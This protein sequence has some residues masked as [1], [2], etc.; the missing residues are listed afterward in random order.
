MNVPVIFA[1][2]GTRITSPVTRYVNPELQAVNVSLALEPE[3]NRQ[4]ESWAMA[5]LQHGL[6]AVLS[7]YGLFMISKARCNKS[8]N[9]G[10]V[11]CNRKNCYSNIMFFCCGYTWCTRKKCFS[12]F[13]LR[14]NHQLQ[15]QF[16]F[17]KSAH[18]HMNSRRGPSLILKSATNYLYF[19]TRKDSKYYLVHNYIIP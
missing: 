10:F 8:T 7:V 16:S 6:R 13:I 4:G 9:L 2:G 11:L 18:S 5:E 12:P 3:H 17:V 1:V 14:H 19:K 15:T